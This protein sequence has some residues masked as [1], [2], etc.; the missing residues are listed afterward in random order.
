MDDYRL[1]ALCITAKVRRKELKTRL[2]IAAFGA[3]VVWWSIGL[4]P[5][6]LWFGAVVMSQVLNTWGWSPL[7]RADVKK[8]TRR[9]YTFILFCSVQAAVVYSF[10]AAMLWFAGDESL[11]VFSFL[12]FAGSLLHVTLHM[13]HDKAAFFAGSAAHGI[14]FFGVPMVTI[15]LESGMDKAGGII[16]LIGAALYSGH[17]IAAFTSTRSLSKGLSDAR[18]EAE[19]RQS[20]AE[21][22][23]RAKSEFLASM[24]HEIRTPLNGILGMSDALLSAELPSNEKERV[25]ILHASGELLLRL[26]ND[27]LDLSKIEAA[28]F[29]LEESKIDI[30]EVATKIVNVHSISSLKEDVAMQL[31]I[32]PDLET[33]RLGDELRLTQILHNLI[34]NAAKFTHSGQITVGIEAGYDNGILIRVQD[35]GIGMSADQLGQIMKP[36]VQA[37]KSISRKYGG[38]GLGLAIVKGIVSAMGGNVVVTSALGMGSCFSVYLPLKP[39]VS[40]GIGDLEGPQE[41][42]SVSDVKGARILVADDNAVNRLVIKSF[43]NELDVHLVYAEDGQQAVDSY[44]QGEFDL[45]LMDIAMPDKDGVEAMKEIKSWEREQG[46]TP[47]PIVAVSAHALS[48]EVT[49]YLAE[50]FDDYLSKPV[51]K[52]RLLTVASRRLC[53]AANS[54][55]SAA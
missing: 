25:E 50:G 16:T 27:M 29:E 3:C 11:R 24:S 47:V 37:D 8:I 41:N 2:F 43:L 46:R 21:S 42:C 15:M 18:K 10:V 14:Y 45:V 28:R 6:L 40:G 4:L 13:H 1:E 39:S 26:L 54:T 55:Q 20:E 35:T 9:Q 19:R 31:T 30:S 33:I 44:M 12:W 38:T 7:T 22:A 5:G 17:L 49:M 48:H 53:H 52:D 51:S 34:S 23:N 36:F 32:A